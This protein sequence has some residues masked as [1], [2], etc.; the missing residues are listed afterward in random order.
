MFRPLRNETPNGR[1]GLVGVKA[2]NEGAELVVNFSFEAVSAQQG[3]AQLPAADSRK[4][5]RI[6]SRMDQR[7]DQAAWSRFDTVKLQAKAVWGPR[8]H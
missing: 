4:A 2:I 7:L 8:V 3:E 5:C 6:G 1:I